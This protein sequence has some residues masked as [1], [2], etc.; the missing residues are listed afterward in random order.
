VEE[1]KRMAY[2]KSFGVGLAL[3]FF[4]F[5][6]WLIWMFAAGAKSSAI[7]I[8]VRSIRS[9]GLWI[10]VVLLFLLGFFFEF[11]RVRSIAGT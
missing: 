1:V 2:L 8:D 9:P 7:S 6:V 10:L 11:R 4:G 5:L 3:A